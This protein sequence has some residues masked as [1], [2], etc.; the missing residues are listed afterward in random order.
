MSMGAEW[1]DERRGSGIQRGRIGCEIDHVCR[2]EPRDHGPHHGDG[3]AGARARLK[4]EQL[5]KE[6][7]GESSRE[8]RA[9]EICAA[10]EIGAAGRCR[11]PGK[12][13][14]GTA[15]WA[16]ARMNGAR[17]TATKTMLADCHFPCRLLRCISICLARP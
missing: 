10:F 11:Q 5:P 8:R 12:A 15:V 16:L 1:I 7:A 13:Q 14:A 3:G 4:P 17:H 6:I 2:R 9:R